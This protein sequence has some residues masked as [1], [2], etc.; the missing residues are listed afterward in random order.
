MYLQVWN[1][2]IEKLSDSSICDAV[3]MKQKNNF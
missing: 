3:G 2:L 1:S